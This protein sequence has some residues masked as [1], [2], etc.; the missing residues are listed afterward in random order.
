MTY[1]RSVLSGVGL[2]S[3]ASVSG[4]LDSIPSGI[5]GGGDGSGGSGGQSR[6]IVTTYDEAF[7]ARNDA[8]TTRDEGITA[9][10]ERKLLRRD[11][12]T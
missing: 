10:N 8:T 12:A 2:L 9:F 3:A 4:C 1:R 7:V 6:Q 5:A 11:R